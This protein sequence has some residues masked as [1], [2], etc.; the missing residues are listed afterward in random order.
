MSKMVYT[1]NDVQGNEG[2]KR[3]DHYN[4][5]LLDPKR[6]FGTTYPGYPE[7]VKKPISR[8]KGKMMEAVAVDTKVSK[9][10]KVTKVKAESPAKAPRDGSKLSKALEV[11][12]ATGK[13][14][15]EA[16][17]VAIVNALSVTRGNASIY[18]AKSLAILG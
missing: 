13:D 7:D 18:Y 15:K 14:D 12:K 11:V 17:L 2:Q 10:V 1:I 6:E 8:K 5:W 16:C 9:P 3:L 4:K